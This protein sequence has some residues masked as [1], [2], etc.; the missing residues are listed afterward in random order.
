[1]SNSRNASFTYTG[2]DEVDPL[3]KLVFECRLDSNDPLAWVDCEYPAEYLNLSPGEHTFE[4]RA[5]DTT[6]M[7]DPSPAR[8]TWTYKP[9][10]ANVAPETTIDLKPEAETWS[11][12][13]LFTFHANEPD[14]SFECKVDN[15][16]Y[17]PCGF[18]EPA[19]FMS[20]GAF[21][22]GLTET[23]V[24]SHTLSVCATDFEGNV[25]AP[26]TYTWRL[27]GITT[28]FLDGPGFTPAT[29]GETLSSDATIEC[30]LDG[31]NFARCSSPHAYWIVE[32][33]TH[34]F[35]VR[36][37]N[38]EGVVEEPPARYEWAVAP[39]PVT[40]ITSGPADTSEET[41]SRDRQV[42]V[43]R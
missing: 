27:L 34:E 37:T 3:N 10:P 7:A 21:E 12:D 18:V 32:N 11:P 41:M 9:L 13:A 36:A 42:R 15:L 24:G 30:S 40:T 23:E 22:W 16:P 31:A 1:V 28:A 35:E 29:G 33:G 38:P 6:Q 26:A 20:M 39:P 25:G 2:R 17:E 8:Y 5:V 14:V 43:L 19:A 4:V